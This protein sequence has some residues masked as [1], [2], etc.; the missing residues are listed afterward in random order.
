MRVARFCAVGGFVFVV[1]FSALWLFYKFLPPIPAV[2]IAYLVAVSVHFCLNKW[3]V[4]K[5]QDKASGSQ[6][7]RYALNVLA[8]WLCTMA[9]FSL[10]IHWLTA[11][12][13]VAKIISVPPTTLLGFVLLKSFVFR[14]T[15]LKVSRGE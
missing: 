8:C 9:V 4:F 7:F 12:V 15:E 2:S 10:A 1:D 3:W 11:N 5:S 13:Y 14:K 6:I